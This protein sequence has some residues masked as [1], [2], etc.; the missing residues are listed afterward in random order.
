MKTIKGDLIKLALGGEFDLIAHGCNCFNIMGAGVAFSIAGAFL[1]GKVSIARR[2]DDTTTPGDINKLGDISVGRYFLPV[3]NEA[4]T[5]RNHEPMYIVNA[6]TQYGT[7]RYAGDNV[8]DTQA[9]AKAFDK[10][11]LIA[12]QH[13]KPFKIGIPMI[14]AGLG[15]GD[16]KAILAVITDVEK[17]YG[18]D[19]TVVEYDG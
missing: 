1:D 7:A 4:A 10:I 9:V 16:W 15:G 6:Y 18:L 8:V 3:W 17:W 13:S 14:G 2:A 12:N 5:K 19:I 11:A